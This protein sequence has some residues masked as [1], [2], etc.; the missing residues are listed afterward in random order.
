MLLT[1]YAHSPGVHEGNW[2]EELGRED[3]PPEPAQQLMTTQQAEY[4]L[5]VSSL[6]AS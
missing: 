3:S 1:L 4:T 6:R 5:E 2:V